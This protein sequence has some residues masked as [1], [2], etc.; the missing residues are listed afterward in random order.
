MIVNKC[1]CASAV[2]MLSAI[3][4]GCTSLPESSR[5]AAIHDVKVEEKTLTGHNSSTAGRRGPLG[6][7]PEAAGPSGSSHGDGR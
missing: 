5:T 3:A 4:Y 1:V 2:L 6:E 7:R